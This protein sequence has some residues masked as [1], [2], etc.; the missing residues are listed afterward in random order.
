MD[1]P[2]TT[3]SQA[4]LW[5]GR[6]GDA[7]VETQDVMD[8]VLQPMG[9]V[10]VDTVAELAPRRVIDIGCGSGQTTVAAARRL[11][12]AEVTGI[13]I[14]E[15]MIAAARARAEREGVDASFVHADVQQYEFEARSAGVV[16]SRFGVMFFD[17]PVLAFSNLRVAA[18]GGG[19][20]R[21]V[22]WR[23]V[24]ENPFMSAAPRAAAPIVP[25]PSIEPNTPGPFGLADPGYVRS[26][27]ESSGWVAIDLEPIDLECTMPEAELV[28]YFTRIGAVGR[29]FGDLDVE[30]QK[31]VLAAVRPAFDPFVDGDEVQFTAA[32]WMV[33]ATAP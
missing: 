31:R 8:R 6:G 20:L 15:P 13:D 12:D 9:D 2:R 21:V 32:C 3:Q 33:S 4:E 24:D 10:L 28:R 14:S 30:T 1:E 7:W 23:S 18:S 29:V 5:N 26:I 25:M 19:S 17:D 27:L 11:V 22:V 16:M